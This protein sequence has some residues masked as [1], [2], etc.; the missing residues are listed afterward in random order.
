MAEALPLEVILNSVFMLFIF[1][2][3]FYGQRLQL[4]LTMRRIRKNLV[5]LERM[6]KDA[7]IKLA[8]S[9]MK[10]NPDEETVKGGLDQL[11]DMFAIPPVRLDPKGIV[12][13]LESILDTYEGKMKEGIRKLA[14]EAG[15][16]EVD[17]LSNLL[18][19]SHGLNMMFKIVRHFYLLAKKTHSPMSIVRLQ[20]NLPFIMEQAEAYH[21]SLDAFAE[22]RSIGDGV[23]AMVA[24]SLLKEKTVREIAKDTVSAAVDVQGR[25]VFVVKAQGPGGN[26]GKPGEAVRRI[27]KR[28]KNISLIVTVDAGLKLEGERS[29]EIVEGSGAAIGGPGVE[30]F[31]IEEVAT[32]FGIPLHAIVVKMSE[33]EVLSGMTEEIEGAAKEATERVMSTILGLS[34]PGSRVIVAGI[35]NTIG[36]P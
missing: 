10:V 14:P 30:R 31:K 32:E 5:K 23:G 26:V 27:I 33:K 11:L 12:W 9:I 16:P 17:N 36:V 18:E 2:T 3:F 19:A 1:G 35:G 13:K 8:E 28:N 6:K 25:K 24:T 29:G 4:F 15:G 21:A 34:E 22:G 7:K 20:M